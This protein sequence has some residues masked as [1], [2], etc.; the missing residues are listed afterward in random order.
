M[1]GMALQ[2]SVLRLP[3]EL[4]W[5]DMQCMDLQHCIA[6]WGVVIALQST[7]YAPMAISNMPATIS[8]TKCIF[9]RA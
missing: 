4:W 7:P 5:L 8:F 9:L 6:C 3:D 1:S 2:Q